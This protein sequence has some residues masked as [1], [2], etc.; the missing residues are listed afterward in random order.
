MPIPISAICD[1]ISSVVDLAVYR[2][3]S[4]NKVTEWLIEKGFLREIAEHLDEI[5]A[6]ANDK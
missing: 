4:Y 2:K 6:K 5:L 1:N 3:L